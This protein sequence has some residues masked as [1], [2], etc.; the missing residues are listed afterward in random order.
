MS[1]EEK[2]TIGKLSN[3]IKVAILEAFE[4]RLKEIKK[5]EVEA[6]LANEFFD[7][8]APA[9]TDTKTHLHPITAVLRQVEDTFKRMGFDIF[10]SN[11]VTTE[12]F[13]FDSL[14]IPATHPA[15]DMQDTFWLE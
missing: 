8:T 9:S 4:M 2:Q 12:F 14:N 5:V 6:K 11:E 1:V 7:V 3:D 10:E 15:R 13:N